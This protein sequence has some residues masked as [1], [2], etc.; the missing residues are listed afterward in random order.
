MSAIT[1]CRRIN[2]KDLAFIH[3]TG[4]EH[5]GQYVISDLSRTALKR[6]SQTISGLSPSYTDED[7]MRE[8][9]TTTRLLAIAEAKDGSEDLLHISSYGLPSLLQSIYLSGAAAFDNNSYYRNAFLA[10]VFIRRKRKPDCHSSLARHV[11]T[12]RRSIMSACLVTDMCHR[13]I[14]LFLFL[15]GLQRMQSLEPWML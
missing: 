7:A 4:K 11:I 14:C 8:N 13:L 6:P 12:T 5:N 3:Y 9:K 10:S 2:A 15:T 1:H